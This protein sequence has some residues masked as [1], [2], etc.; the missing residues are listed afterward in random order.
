LPDAIF[1]DFAAIQH[2]AI[3]DIRNNQRQKVLL[4]NDYEFEKRVD[5]LRK[6]VELR[7]FEPLTS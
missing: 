6:G 4:G 2:R 5:D 7:G 3:S 1:G